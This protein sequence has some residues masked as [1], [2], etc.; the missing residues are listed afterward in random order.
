MPTVRSTL[1]AGAGLVC[2][3]LAGPALHGQASTS[4]PAQAAVTD[5]EACTF[6][7]DKVK[8]GTTVPLPALCTE[9]RSTKTEAHYAACIDTLDA[10]K[11]DEKT[12][13]EWLFG[14]CYVTTPDGGKAMVKP[15]PTATICASLARP[16]GPAFC[17]VPKGRP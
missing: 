5:C 15:C 14:G 9:L 13:R 11:R 4:P 16:Q 8:R 10:A 12:F 17:P 3:A 2:L 6:V 1:V 7:I